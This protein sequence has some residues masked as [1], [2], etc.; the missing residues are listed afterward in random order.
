MGSVL[1]N[2]VTLAFWGVSNESERNFLNG[3]TIHCH[4]KP[5]GIV[6]KV[7]P[8]LILWRCLKNRNSETTPYANVIMLFM[9]RSYLVD[10]PFCFYSI[11]F[12]M[13][14]ICFLMFS[15]TSIIHTCC[16]CIKCFPLCGVLYK[17][18]YLHNHLWLYYTLIW[19]CTKWNLK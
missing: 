12:G 5:S 19:L 17:C 4:P 16:S 8:S 15:T 18:S 13:Q 1:V 14:F 11:I 2:I 7:V 3:D 6:I 10:R 9:Q